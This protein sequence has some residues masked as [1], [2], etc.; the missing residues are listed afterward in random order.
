LV[1]ALGLWRGFPGGLLA[2]HP[3]SSDVLS[4]SLLWDYMYSSIVQ[5][6][7]EVKLSRPVSAR[8][9]EPISRVR[10]VHHLT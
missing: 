10:D 9:H 2:V 3:H 6:K 7:T 4:F 1:K 8:A 5:L